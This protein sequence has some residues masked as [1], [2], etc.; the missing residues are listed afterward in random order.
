MIILEILYRFQ[1][2]EIPND[3]G[4]EDEDWGYLDI[5]PAS[6]PPEEVLQAELESQTID[7]F[8]TEDV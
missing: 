7:E 1:E 6:P 3:S 5:P 2:T 8:E 4:D